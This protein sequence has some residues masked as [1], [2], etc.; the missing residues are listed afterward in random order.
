MNKKKPQLEIQLITVTD[1]S[2]KKW[3]YFIPEEELRHFQSYL[4]Q[5]GYDNALVLLECVDPIRYRFIDVLD[6]TNEG[7]F[8]RCPDCNGDLRLQEQKGL[9]ASTFHGLCAG[10]GSLFYTLDAYGTP[11]LF[12]LMGG[13][14]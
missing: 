3:D 7:V 8:I 12:K 14:I 5:V 11:F 1:P 2:G 13:K 9:N 10:C 6:K 4:D